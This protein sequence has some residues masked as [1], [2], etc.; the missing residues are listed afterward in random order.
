MRRSPANSP[1]RVPPLV[2]DWRRRSIA[3]ISRIRSGLGIRRSDFAALAL[4][5]TEKI[6]FD[7]VPVQHRIGRVLKPLEG[8]L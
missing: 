4:I 1:F 8:H 2:G 3:S 7:L 6:T 5:C